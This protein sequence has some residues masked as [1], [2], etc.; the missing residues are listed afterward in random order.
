MNANQM[1]EFFKKMVEEG[2]GDY[3]V[4]KDSGVK[5]SDGCLK[6][7]EMHRDIYIEQE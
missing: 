6:V 4:R 2:K 3:D 5:C 7:D 1:Y